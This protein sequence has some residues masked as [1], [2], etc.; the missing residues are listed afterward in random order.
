M[1]CAF[2]GDEAVEEGA[3]APPGVFYVAC[4]GHDAEFP[5]LM[6]DELAAE[7][8][9]NGRVARGILKRDMDRV[10][11]ACTRSQP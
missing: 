1:V 10:F 5:P 9:E 8:F 6:H 3:D 7:I 11:W 4:V 2:S